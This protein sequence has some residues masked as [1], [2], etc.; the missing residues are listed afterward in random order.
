M[1][2]ESPLLSKYA[3]IKTR[4][5]ELTSACSGFDAN[6]NE[7][8]ASLQEKLSNEHFNLAVVGQF[9]RGKTS[10]VNA[11][12]GEALLPS[13]VIPLTSTVTVISYAELPQFSIRLRDGCVR[14]IDSSDLGVYVTG[15]NATDQDV[16]EVHARLPAAFLKSGIRLLDTPGVG[17]VYQANTDTA[18]AALPQCDAILFLLSVDQPLS[19]AE[20]DF[21]RDVR[22]YAERIFFI[23]N[24]IDYLSGDDL[25]QALH[26]TR[27]TLEHAFGHAVQIF[28]LSS[29]QALKAA[30]DDLPE[31]LKTSRLPEL[32][33]VLENFLESEKG[34]VLLH[35][36]VRRLL[37]P[38]QQRSFELQLALKSLG[39]PLKELDD[40]IRR[41]HEQQIRIE[42]EKQV[43]EQHFRSESERAVVNL[44]DKTLKQFKQTLTLDLN[45]DFDKFVQQH[46]T[47]TPK[48]LTQEMDN[49]IQQ[50][51][52][53]AFVDWQQG[54][55]VTLYSELESREQHFRAHIDALLQELRD[56]S[57]RLFDVRPENIR[58]VANG[59]AAIETFANETDEP[60][61]LELLL[62][63]IAVDWRNDNVDTRLGRIK[64]AIVRISKTWVIERHRNRLMEII[65]MHAGR[66]RYAILN[67][68]DNAQSAFCTEIT[69]HLEQASAGI[70][71]VLKQSRKTREQD[72]RALQQQQRLQE[73]R[74]EQALR[75][76][77]ELQQ[78]TIEINAL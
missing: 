72:A 54:M 40:K 15:A 44:L 49:W 36:A 77:E 71:H 22:Q 58:A 56:Y 39:L 13:G 17:S 32:T 57:S 53:R 45:I 34:K 47:L 74:L 60:V 16:R 42:R 70:V 14:E 6:N 50:Q 51:V 62:E 78:L 5:L 31:L 11:L 67:R 9:K 76:K 35:G 8:Y 24:K 55:A 25:Q 4:L 64:A 66:A 30:Q 19:Q 68:L 38:I 59:S 63:A 28:P 26:F 18:Y 69:R 43:I 23:L 2:E 29:T 75:L 73:N 65:E 46:E 41:F 37:T 21:L 27:T 10:L 61:G 20:L 3:A 33:A 48:A 52:G 12:L 1:N 7:L